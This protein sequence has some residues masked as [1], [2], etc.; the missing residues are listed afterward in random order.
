[1]CVSFFS[2][3]SERD[4][5]VFL[6]VKL[7]TFP[8]YPCVCVRFIGLGV[9]RAF[10]DADRHKR[11]SLLSK[12]KVLEE[13]AAQLNKQKPTYAFGSSTPRVL[14][15]LE[16]LQ[17]EQKIYDTKLS[18]APLTPAEMEALKAHSRS[19]LDAGRPQRSHTP[20]S[21]VRVAF[22]T[23]IRDETPKRTCIHL[24]SRHRSVTHP[25]FVSFI[26]ARTTRATSRCRAWRRRRA[27]EAVGR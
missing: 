9:M 26:Q 5:S 4:W 2:H 3:E 14:G 16:H 19:S 18:A 24:L 8:D 15:Y 27:H 12:Y 10:Q 20:N 7:M 11:E 22:G 17:K 13:R 1:M 6:L 21:N 25:N 23:I